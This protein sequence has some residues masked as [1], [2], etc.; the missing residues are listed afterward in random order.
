[1][2]TFGG[3][4][5]TGRVPAD[6]VALTGS[7]RGCPKSRGGLRHAGDALPGQTP[8]SA[9]P[10]H[11]EGPG[12]APP[13]LKGNNPGRVPLKGDTAKGDNRVCAGRW[14]AKG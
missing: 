5:E 14:V 8:P 3:W 7:D 2:V 10:G 1:M 9:L 4:S 11:A 12:P 13:P 6:A